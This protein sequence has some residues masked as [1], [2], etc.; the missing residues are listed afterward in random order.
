METSPEKCLIVDVDMN[1]IETT[2]DE[3]LNYSDKTNLSFTIIAKA[4]RVHCIR[5]AY[6]GRGRREVGSGAI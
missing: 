5:E 2:F 3:I 6:D 1:F 4:L